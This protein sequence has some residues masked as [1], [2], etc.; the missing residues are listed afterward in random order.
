MAPAA[1]M[2]M[3]LRGLYVLLGDTMRLLIAA[4]V[5]SS[6]SSLTSHF[7]EFGTVDRVKSGRDVVL[8]CINAIQTRKPY[9]LVFLEPQSGAVD[10]R[11]ALLMIRGYEEDHGQATRKTAICYISDDAFDQQQ[12]RSRFGQ[13]SKTHFF[14]A[15]VS[16]V[17][18]LSLI[19]IAA[20]EAGERSA[21]RTLQ[22][23]AMLRPF[24][25]S[26]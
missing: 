7:E 10:M 23:A 1:R 18:L 25:V 3:A 8:A 4:P 19:K 11:D 2:H 16:R 21:S 17:V 6:L 26:V 14:A 22:K 9:D 13:D 12:Y 20:N 15:P 24:S 5:S